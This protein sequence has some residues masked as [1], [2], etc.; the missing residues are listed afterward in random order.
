M[1]KFHIRKGWGLDRWGLRK[2]H[3]YETYIFCIGKI[4][5]TGTWFTTQ[6]SLGTTGLDT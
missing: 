1:E 2:T 6:K 5:N 4:E 3:M